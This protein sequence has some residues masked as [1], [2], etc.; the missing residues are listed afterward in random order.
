M[1]RNEAKAT[2]EEEVMP[3]REAT[4][5]EKVARDIWEATDETEPWYPANEASLWLGYAV[6]ALATGEDTTSRD[7]HNAWSA[8]AVVHYDGY[9]KSLIPFD[10]LSLDVQAYDDLYRDAIRKIAARLDPDD[11]GEPVVTSQTSDFEAG[12]ER[13]IVSTMIARYAI[14]APGQ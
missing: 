13:I 6:L 9:H 4:Y 5:I 12:G 14:T 11:D 7:V 10:E 3:K 8:W 1:C 2:T